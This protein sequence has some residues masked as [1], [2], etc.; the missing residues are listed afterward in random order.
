MLSH[1]RGRKQITAGQ[2][3]SHTEK[4]VQQAIK[5]ML[6]ACEIDKQHVHIILCDNIR[7]MKK[8][9]DDMEVP[10]VGCV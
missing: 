9:V 1:L 5:A 7:N 2:V 4:R 6:N 8:A 10:S 3:W